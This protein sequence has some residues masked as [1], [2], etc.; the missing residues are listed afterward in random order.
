M[1]CFFLWLKQ[2]SKTSKLP[3]DNTIYAE[4]KDIENLLK[5]LEDKRKVAM[6]WFILVY[7]AKRTSGYDRR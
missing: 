4:H 7:Q 2:K 5:V 3:D 1:I 6:N